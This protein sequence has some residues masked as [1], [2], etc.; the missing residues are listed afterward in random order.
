MQTCICKPD[1]DLTIIRPNLKCSQPGQRQQCDWH[2]K[3]FFS[4]VIETY[5]VIIADTYNHVHLD[6]YGYKMNWDTGENNLDMILFVSLSVPEPSTPLKTCSEGY[7]TLTWGWIKMLHIRPPSEPPSPY[8]YHYLPPFLQQ[9]AWQAII[10]LAL[11]IQG[12]LFECM[13]SWVGITF[14][15]VFYSQQ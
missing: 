8:P 13:Y 7:I 4:S 6:P 5:H 10:S 9:H 12:H 15:Y 14:K 1:Q 2:S 3:I 11:T